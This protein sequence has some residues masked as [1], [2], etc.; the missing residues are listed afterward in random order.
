MDT[1]TGPVD[2]GGRTGLGAARAGDV[3]AIIAWTG[4]GTSLLA[5][6]SVVLH[7]PGAAR[8]VFVLAFCCLGPGAA[9]VSQIRIP[10][11][12]AAWTLTNVL[13]LAVWAVG[14]AMLA[15]LHAWSPETLLVILA[16]ATIIGGAAA[17]VRR[18]SLGPA[19]D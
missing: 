9:L 15:W 14:S 12:A 4:I 2:A 6:L 19:R 8:L 17:L 5:V 7:A 16:T 10:G 13:S 3:S 1:A 18:P 11:A